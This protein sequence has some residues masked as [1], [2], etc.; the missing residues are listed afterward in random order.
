MH[1]IEVIKTESQKLKLE[2]I[3]RVI[4]DDLEEAIRALYDIGDGI[5]QI[6]K[7]LFPLRERVVSKR[8]RLENERDRQEKSSSRTS[9]LFFLY[10]IYYFF[11]NFRIILCKL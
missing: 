5:S 8:I 10:R 2:D 7:I 11:K 9:F 3:E 4:P 6:M 1:R